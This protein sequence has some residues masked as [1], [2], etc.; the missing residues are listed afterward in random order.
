MFNFFIIT[1]MPRLAL[2]LLPI[3]GE[4]DPRA[5]SG[6]FIDVTVL[7]LPFLIFVKYS[8]LLPTYGVLCYNNITVLTSSNLKVLLLFIGVLDKY[9]RG[10]YLIWSVLNFDF[11]EGNTKAVGCN[12]FIH[13]LEF[14][15][16]LREVV[17]FFLLILLQTVDFHTTF[18]FV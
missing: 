12:R 15:L 3:V 2:L 10:R 16:Y 9:M 4:T 1:F 18:M 7:K 8:G 5:I 13:W 14:S 11:Y 6:F 17:E